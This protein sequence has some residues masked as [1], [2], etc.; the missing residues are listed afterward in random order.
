VMRRNGYE[1]S[2]RHYGKA[3]LF[4][5]RAPYKAYDSSARETSRL[6]RYAV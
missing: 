5:P 4:A 2:S 1:N 6:S 3:S